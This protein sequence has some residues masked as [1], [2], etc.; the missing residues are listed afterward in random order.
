MTA[1]DIISAFAEG[2]M[3]PAESRNI[4]GDHPVACDPLGG[5]IIGHSAPVVRY[6]SDAERQCGST[7]AVTKKSFPR[8]PGIMP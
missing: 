8:L 1:Q 5:R 6:H 2:K 7:K 3:L 4:G